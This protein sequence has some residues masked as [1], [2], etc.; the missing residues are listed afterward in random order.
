MKLTL[1]HTD[2]IIAKCS[3]ALLS[4]EFDTEEP[5]LCANF[6]NQ[7]LNRAA[8]SHEEAIFSLCRF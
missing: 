2:C 6:A 4:P 7:G 1:D 3:R 5:I 8:F